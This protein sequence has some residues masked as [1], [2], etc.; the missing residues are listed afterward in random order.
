MTSLQHTLSAHHH[1][2]MRLASH[3]VNNHITTRHMTPCLPRSST[4]CRAIRIDR[5]RHLDIA[6]ERQNQQ[7]DQLQQVGAWIHSLRVGARVAILQHMCM[8][9]M[10]ITSAYTRTAC[11]RTACTGP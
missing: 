9:N 3:R 1:T 4:C 6:W 7:E 10:S 8:L 5:R 11:T 2:P